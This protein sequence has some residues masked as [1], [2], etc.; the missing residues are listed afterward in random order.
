MQNDLIT[1]LMQVIYMLVL[2][3]TNRDLDTDF[4]ISFGLS[5]PYPQYFLNRFLL[6]SRSSLAL[7]YPRV[8]HVNHFFSD[9][10]HFQDFSIALG[11]YLSSHCFKLDYLFLLLL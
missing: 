9:L 3:V 4:A 8:N 2:F 1:S 7:D 10:K 6:G 11:V 5:H